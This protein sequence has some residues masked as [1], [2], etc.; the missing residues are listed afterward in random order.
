MRGFRAGAFRREQMPTAL[1]RFS[2]AEAIESLEHIDLDALRRAGKRVIL[3]DVDNTLLPW[4][5]RDIPASTHDWLARGR[6]LGFDFCVLSNTRNPERLEALTKE[7]GI[8]YVRDKFKPS[9]KMFVR[10]LEKFGARPDEAVMIGDQLLTDVLGAN[11]A[12]IDAI[13][14]RPL[15]HREFVGT[16][17]LSRNLER[18]LGLFLHKYFQ[19]IEPETAVAAVKPGF[20]DHHI[21]KQFVKFCT[22]GATSTVIDAGLHFLLMFVVTVQGQ[23]LGEVVGSRA[24]TILPALFGWAETPSDAAIPILKVPTAC[25]AILNA[26]YWNGRWTFDSK[27]SLRRYF[28]VAL[29]GMALNTMFTTLF[30]HMVVGAPKA[31]WAI[32]TA[33][34]T[35]IVAFWNFFGSRLFVFKG[36]RH[37]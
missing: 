10:A 7:M 6:E 18:L 33:I 22:V 5:S 14:V 21:V 27:G 25:L 2:P 20:F 36:P 35:V 3:L 13:W 24:A 29:T 26:Y 28:A 1:R 16:R 31:S 19:V 37:G 30:N 15:H 32:A 11:R 17:Y 34:A 9:T 8:G 12:G 23:P 4:R